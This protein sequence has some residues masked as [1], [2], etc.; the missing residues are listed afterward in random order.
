M[1]VLTI[2]WVFRLIC[3]L[4]L[5]VFGLFVLFLYCFVYVDLFLLL[6]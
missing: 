1:G 2:V 4:V 6:V 5:T 3:V